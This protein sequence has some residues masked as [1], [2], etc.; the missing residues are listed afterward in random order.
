MKRSFWITALTAASLAACSPQPAQKAETAPAPAAPAAKAPVN[1]ASPGAYK[2][3]ENHA[4]VTF[5]VS[6]LGMSRYTARFTDIEADLQFDPANPAA[7]SVSATIDPRS[8][9]TDFHGDKPDFDAELAGPSWLDS[10]KFPKI[11][12]KS[13]KV[14]VTGPATAKVTGDLTLHG[15]TRPVTLETTFNGG[16]KPSAMDPGSRIG[17]S[18]HGVLKRSEFGVSYG[19]PAPGSNFGVGDEVEVMIEAEFTQAAAAPPA[20]ATPAS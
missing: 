13:T 1:E 15:V 18:A 16:S 10:A 4:S 14:D 7:M 11:T 12:F 2:I 9:E 8:I 20:P 6:H 19:V 5:R 17:F 3:D